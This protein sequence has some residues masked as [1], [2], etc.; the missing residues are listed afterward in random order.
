MNNYIWD[1]EVFPNVFLFGAKLAGSGMVWQYEI[2]DRI[3]ESAEIVAFCDYLTATGARG[4]GFNNVGFDYPILHLLLKMRRAD[5]ATLYQKCQAI[6][7]AQDENRWLHGVKPA[8][9]L[10]EQIDLFLIHHFDNRA[11][12]TS[13]KALQFNMRRPSIRDLPFAVGSVLTPEQILALRPYNRHDLDTTEDFYNASIESIRFREQL[14]QKYQRDFMNHNDTKIG[15]DFFVM[16]LERAGIPCYDYSPHTGRSPRQT[17][18]P[19]IHLREAILPSIQFQTPDLQ[20]VLNWLKEQSISETKGVFKDLTAKVGNFELVFGTGGLHGSV[21]NARVESDA[22][23]V[24][25]DLDVASMYPNIA[26]ANRFRPAHYPEKFCDIYASL[27]EQRKAHAKGTPENAMLKLA[28][29]GS[30]G[31]GNDPYS[32]FYDPLF[33]LQITLTGQLQ[34]SMLIEWLVTYVPGLQMV[35]ANTDGVSVRI[36]RTSEAT[37]DGIVKHWEA[38]T[39]LT[40]EKAKF[41]RLHIRDVNNY[42]GQYAS[43]VLWWHAES[44]CYFWAEHPGGGADGALCADVTDDPRHRAAALAA[45]V[46][47]KFSPPKIKRK[48]AYEYQMQWHQDYSALVVPKVAEQVLLH[49]KPIRETVE[50]WPDKMDFMLRIKV[51]RTGY[52]SIRSGPDAPETQVQNLSRYYVAR[53]GVQMGKWLPPLKGKTEWRRT[54]VE[55]GWT[56]CVCNEIGEGTLPID[57]DYYI[58]EVEKLCLPV[59]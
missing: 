19:I 4:I 14:S 48:G 45:G 43:D 13:L 7:D 47:E 31:A 25:V 26:I 39:R 16:E 46:A 2:S 32:V 17:R 51:P 9:R 55:A 20:R 42:I 22:E 21:E 23:H 53:G 18:R 30:F 50:Q 1:V 33:L 40:M 35:Q 36:P 58:N 29:N 12:S 34:L 11:R 24:I 44:E 3:N 57:Y 8:D 52:L 5:A 6:I 54:S 56:V 15:K 59:M 28:L 27:Y 37:L 41:K 49:D 10:F 38:Y